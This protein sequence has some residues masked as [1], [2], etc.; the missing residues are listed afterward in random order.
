VN[1]WLS[2][3]D[4]LLLEIV[5]AG[6]VTDARALDP[7]VCPSQYVRNNGRPKPDFPGGAVNGIASKPQMDT[8]G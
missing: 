5:L 4:G 1:C 2:K 6:L 8:S 3:L 7:T